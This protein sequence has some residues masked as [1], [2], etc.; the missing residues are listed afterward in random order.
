MLLLIIINQS[1]VFWSEDKLYFVLNISKELHGFKLLP[2]ILNLKS[3]DEVYTSV[4]RYVINIKFQMFM[5]SS[6]LNTLGCLSVL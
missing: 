3:K 1:E 6:M 2:I 5:A 4:W